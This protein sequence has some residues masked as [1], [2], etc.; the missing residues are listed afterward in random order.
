MHHVTYTV[1]AQ[2]PIYADIYYIDHEPAIFADYS[3]NPYSFTPNIQADIAPGKPWS[4]ELE[5]ANPDQWA[6]VSASSGTEPGTPQFH[7][8]L[9]VD[10][11]V[12][13]SKDGPKGVL[14]SLRHW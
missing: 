9:S 10:G 3:H 12:V 6:M 8:D 11:T 7:C 1:T 2:N 4:F 5:L 14:C 13:V